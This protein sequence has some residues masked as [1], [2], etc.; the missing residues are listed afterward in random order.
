[1][2]IHTGSPLAW[3]PQSN[4]VTPAKAKDIS[5]LPE[6]AYNSINIQPFLLL[7]NNQYGRFTQT[8]NNLYS[9]L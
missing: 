4:Q 9:N 5:C 8:R 2:N 6:P 1:M 7:H 3:R